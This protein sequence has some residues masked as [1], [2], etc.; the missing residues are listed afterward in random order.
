[1]NNSPSIAENPSAG[2][3]SMASRY[4]SD[5]E[6]DVIRTT[7][8]M[9]IIKQDLNPKNSAD[10]K[11][12]STASPRPESPNETPRHRFRTFDVGVYLGLMSVGLLGLLPAVMIT[13]SALLLSGV[14]DG[15]SA[16]LCAL[17]ALAP[18]LILVIATMGWY[19]FIEQK[20]PS[21]DGVGDGSHDDIQMAMA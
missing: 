7:I 5:E 3:A 8:I 4:L 16:I 15:T 1:M 6:E 21:H 11:T 20:P 17:L 9:N 2:G 14:I 18:V 13:I 10:D 12:S 19:Y